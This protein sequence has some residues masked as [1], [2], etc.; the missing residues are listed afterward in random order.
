MGGGARASVVLARRYHFHMPGITYAAT[1]CVLVLGALNGQNNL[2]FWLFGL[3]VAG[4]IIS[5]VLSGA[6]L[7]GIEVERE[8]PRTGAVGERMTLRYSVRNR[9]RLFPAFGLTIEELEG[10]G[11]SETWPRAMARPVAFAAYVPARGQTVVEAVVMLRRR[12]EASFGRTRAW[13]TFPFGLTKKSVTFGQESRVLV[14][15]RAAPLRAGI[16]E[17]AAGAGD[18]GAR[19]R[20]ER[21]GD[22]FFGLREYAPGDSARSIA[23]RSTA[24]L[25]R[26]VVREMA[27]RPSRRVWIVPAI[28]GLGDELAERAIGVALGLVVRAESAGFEVG[29]ATEDG[30]PLVSP[31]PGRRQV[32]AAA[33]ALARVEVAS[34]GS[35]GPTGMRSVVAHDAVLVVGDAS[36]GVSWA[37]GAHRVRAD[38]AAIYATGGATGGTV[39]GAGSYEAIIRPEPPRKKVRWWIPTFGAGD[40]AKPGAAADAGRGTGGDA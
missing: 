6:A 19:L 12:G 21:T 1:T 3:A 2:L 32:Q 39:G 14:V 16:V 31:S 23:W 17:E 8:A 27:R 24:R 10:E 29:I 11:A 28:T 26:S 20:R 5:G 38:D 35:A 22:E 36:A 9:N 4:L 25:G 13:T 7:M 34:V 40:V 18:R 15:P 30:R 37:P 33:E